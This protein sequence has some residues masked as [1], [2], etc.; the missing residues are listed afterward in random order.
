MTYL[1]PYTMLRE[2]KRVWARNMTHPLGVITLTLNDRES[3]TFPKTKDPVCLNDLAPEKS[4][5]ESMSLRDLVRKGVL[6]IVS[7]ESAQEYFRAS[8]KSPRDSFTRKELPDVREAELRKELGI[9]EMPVKPNGETISPSVVHVVISL[10]QPNLSDADVIS[11]LSQ[12]W[13]G[14][15]QADINYIMS[16]IG[17]A[18]VVRWIA[19]RMASATE[20]GKILLEDELQR[21]FGEASPEPPEG[22]LTPPI[23]KGMEEPYN[24]VFQ[25]R[26]DDQTIPPGVLTTQPKPKVQKVPTVKPKKPA[27]NR[28]SVSVSR[29]QK[30]SL[31][32]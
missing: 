5:L 27:P 11:Y 12:A 10:Q 8:G 22:V 32:A 16:R 14:F 19:G 18:E 9:S 3:I 6:Q 15:S 7:D 17:R 13:D 26:S 4:L 21:E 31:N 20:T 23:P 25:S 29:T 28:K 30:E 24:P 2:G 1:D